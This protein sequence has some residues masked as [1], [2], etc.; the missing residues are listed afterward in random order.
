MVSSRI[1]NVHPELI[2]VDILVI[3]DLHTTER[4][5]CVGVSIIFVLI[6]F[7]LPTKLTGASVTLS[8]LFHARHV[9]AIDN[10]K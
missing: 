9:F 7:Y 8:S 2:T 6:K 4:T 5:L 3:A 10:R 1:A